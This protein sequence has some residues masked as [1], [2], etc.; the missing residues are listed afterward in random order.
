[1]MIS[2]VNPFPG[3]VT[4]WLETVFFG[5]ASFGE[6]GSANSFPAHPVFVPCY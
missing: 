3:A 1:M 5:K 6:K 2:I 4:H